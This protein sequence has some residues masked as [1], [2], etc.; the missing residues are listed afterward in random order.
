[1]YPS[2]VFDCVIT[3]MNLLDE[4]DE[5]LIRSAVGYEVSVVITDYERTLLILIKDP[6]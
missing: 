1:M 2:E 4:F 6:R 5:M 3:T